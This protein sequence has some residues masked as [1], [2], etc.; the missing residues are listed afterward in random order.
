VAQ[1]GGNTCKRRWEVNR[2]YTEGPVNG[3]K[4]VHTK[5]RILPISQ[6]GIIFMVGI[7]IGGWN[8]QKGEKERAVTVIGGMISGGTSGRFKWTKAEEN[9]LLKTIKGTAIGEK[10]SS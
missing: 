1:R 2:D 8:G 4:K 10:G 9:A 7:K 3:I 6:E 5:C